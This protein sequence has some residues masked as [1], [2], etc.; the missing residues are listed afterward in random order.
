MEAFVSLEA[1][2]EGWFESP[3]SVLPVEIARTVSLRFVLVGWDALSPEQR[4]VF[5]R[6]WDLEHDPALEGDRQRAWALVMELEELQARLARWEAVP[7]PSALNLKEKE[8]QLRNLREAIKS[9]HSKLDARPPRPKASLQPAARVGD[10]A[11]VA[12]P[13]ALAHLRQRLKATPE[14]LAAWIF[15]GPE[16]GGLV[17]HL[18]PGAEEPPPRFAFPTGEPRR[19]GADHDYVPLMMGCWFARQDIEQFEPKARYT[20][21]RDL[22]A[23]WGSLPGVDAT[24]FVRAK[25]EESRLIDLHPVYGGTRISTGDDDYPP[26]ELGLFRVADVEAI[27][28]EDFGG[29]PGAAGAEGPEERRLRLTKRRAQ[30]QA[31]RVRNFNQVLAEE[32]GLSVERIKQL[33]KPKTVP[34]SPDGPATWVAPIQQK[35]SPSPRPRMRKD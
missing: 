29:L 34:P 28:A 26:V 3:L 23:R 30:L 5:A 15:M 12:Y 35:G 18:Q 33:L 8:A 1:R 20:T 17:A 27:E 13:T 10:G 4:R 22:L 19:M 16:R 21:G 24:A 32:E 31:A 9:V 11:Y 7:T 25:I 2:L 14:E 6:H